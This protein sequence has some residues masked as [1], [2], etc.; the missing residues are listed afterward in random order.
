M[1][2]VLCILLALGLLLGCRGEIAAMEPAAT[3]KFGGGGPN[4][5]A[6]RDASP[7]PYAH[8]IPH[9]DPGT[10]AHAGAHADPGAHLGPRPAH[11]RPDL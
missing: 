10:H 4:A 2:R 5:G 9:A 6:H 7:L 8:R 1:K 11:D 3:P